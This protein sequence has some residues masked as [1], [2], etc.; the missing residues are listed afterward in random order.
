MN[1]GLILSLKHQPLN[2]IL[3]RFCSNITIPRPCSTLQ[4]L[5]SYATHLYF[6]PTLRC[7]LCNNFFFFNYILLKWFC[8][9][10][11]TFLILLLGSKLYYYLDQKVRSLDWSDQL[12][13]QLQW[14]CTLSLSACGS[15][16]YHHNCST[17]KRLQI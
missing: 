12:S 5:A 16:F 4:T 17:I 8:P 14:I 6:V 1:C 2:L 11:S 15:I 9:L 3:L 10:I 13:T 7:T